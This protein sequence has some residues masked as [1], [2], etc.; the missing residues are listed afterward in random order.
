[1]QDTA[2]VLPKDRVQVQD[3]AVGGG[4]PTASSSSPL[5]QPTS[6]DGTCTCNLPRIECSTQTRMSSPPNTNFVTFSAHTCLEL[7]PLLTPEQIEFEVRYNNDI[8]CRNLDF[9]T[10]QDIVDMKAVK[11]NAL[12]NSAN[13]SLGQ[14]FKEIFHGCESYSYLTHELS[15]SISEAQKFVDDLKRPVV[16]PE[17]PSI[18]KERSSECNLLPP[19]CLLEFNVG[20][21][22]SVQHFTDCI[23]FR[24]I[25]KRRVAHFGPTE[26]SYGGIRHE[27]AEYPSCEALDTVMSRVREHTGELRFNKEEWSCT[28]THYPDSTSHIPMHSDDEDC[29]IPGSVI[30][31]VSIGAA[32]TVTFQN[33]IGPLQ[34]PQHI[35]LQHGSVHLMSHASQFQWQHGILPSSDQECGPRISLTFRRLQSQ[36]RPHIPPISRPDSEHDPTPGTPINTHQSHRPKRVLFLSDSVHISFP[37]HLFNPSNSICIKKRLPNFCL[38]DIQNFESEFAYTD[39]VFLSCGVNDLSRYKWSARKLTDYICELLRKY[40]RLFPNTRFIFNSVLL[41]D[42]AW[43]N[44]EI[45]LL[46][47]NLFQASL[48]HDS[49]LWFFDSHHVAK[50]YSRRSGE[51]VI[52]RSGRRAN[53]VHI[54]YGVTYEI[55][56]VIRR[57]LDSLCCGSEAVT[58]QSWPLRDHYRD[59]LA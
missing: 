31:T 11:L 27:A 38:S 29:I 37:T 16:R 44:D 50:L 24:S 13:I 20:D 26:Y 32:R 30:V 23:E 4:Q 14:E 53:G 22:L 3:R 55:R 36:E 57:C 46:N 7:L 40:A 47:Y 58:T 48:T 59:L 39:Y 52:E 33:I 28:V 49:N 56:E 34:P 35:P 9:N 41:T 2:D 5:P 8:L 17:I 51:R 25:S 10:N 43:L 42:F 54:T 21:G 15:R 6:Q 45:D 1:M 12:K 19:V 18:E